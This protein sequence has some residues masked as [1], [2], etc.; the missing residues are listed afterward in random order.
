[1]GIR[2]GT[3]ERFG[4]GFGCERRWRG[5]SAAP[6]GGRHSGGRR[7]GD[8]PHA[9]ERLSRRDDGGHR[10]A[11]VRCGE[12][13]RPPASSRTGRSGTSRV[14]RTSRTRSTAPTPRRAPRRRLGRRRRSRPTRTR[15]RCASYANT[16]ATGKQWPE[17]HALIDTLDAAPPGRLAVGGRP[18][19]RQ[20]RHAARLD[21]HP[22]LDPRPHHQH[23]GRVLRGLGH[24]AVPLRDGLGPRGV[25]ARNRTR[26]AAFRTVTRTAS[27]SGS[28][29]LQAMGVNYFIAHDPTTKTQA[30]S[31]PRLTLVGVVARPRRRG[32][33]RLEHLPG[34]RCTVR[35]GALVRAGRRRRRRPEPRRLGAEDRGA[36]VVVPRPARQA[37]VVAD[38]PSELAPRRGVGGAPAPR[39]GRST[40]AQ[41]TERQDGPTTRSA[42]TSTESGMPVLV[43]T[44]YFPNWKVDGA[45]G[46]YRVDA[47]LHGGGPDREARDP[48]LRDHARPSGWADS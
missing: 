21:A 28:K 40:P 27:T 36:V 17:Y 9:G 35:R 13:N 33:A 39:A 38:G 34:C 45:E 2:T 44:S 32:T 42:S 6:A 29:Y 26:S 43:K 46:P 8:R 10:G 3:D 20:V 19:A 12:G 30:D 47:Q 15:R 37:P 23:G 11:R 41:V 5:A 25:R 14:T 48:P 16:V 31:D 24:D 22:V 1:M 7:S 4:R 18:V